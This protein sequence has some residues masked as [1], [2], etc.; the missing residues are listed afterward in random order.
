MNSIEKKILACSAVLN[1]DATQL[2][3]LRDLL[4]R[5]SDVDR[6]INITVKEGLANLLYK[7]L[8]KSDI[9]ET[10][11]PKQQERLHSLYYQTLAFNLK[12]M[13]DLKGILHQLNKNSY[14]V[15]LLQGI[16]LLH[17]TYEDIGLR[18]LTDIDLWVLQK[19]YPG[20]I[21]IL[22]SRGYE[23]D[24]LYPNT[25]KKGSTILDLH[26]HILWADRIKSRMFIISK[27]QEHIFQDTRIID[28]DGQKALCLGRY[29]QVLYLSLHV[30]KHNAERLIWLV[31]IK[32]LLAGWEGCDWEALINRARE[33][34]MDRTVL[35][36]FFL[37]L[38]IFD[39]QPP[40]EARRVF[41]GKRLHF[42]EKMVLRQRTRSHS[43]P[44]WGSLILFPSGRGLG[45]RL[46]FIVET[47]FPRPEI[48]RQVFVV[49]SDW[50]FWRLYCKRIIQLLVMIKDYCRGKAG[51]LNLTL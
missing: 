11:T 45:G 32:S 31:D 4:P 43:L 37:L 40:L 22:S 2:D 47:L 27:N 18:P 7:S 3:R 33:L 6:L 39:F 17:E 10:L 41:K 36:I 26:T 24:P 8:Q 1:P 21:S 25:F 48:L 51:G 13:E 20:V 50:P 38:H 16:D 12:L 29:D 5:C 46:S 30:L 15:V 9:L 14:Q 23:R 49:S 19:D 28:F 34:G 42:I 44:V 35:Y